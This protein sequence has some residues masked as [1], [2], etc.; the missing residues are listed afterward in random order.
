MVTFKERA[1]YDWSEDSV[2]IM[3]TPSSIARNTFF[4]VQEIGSFQTKP[5]YFTEREHLPSYLIVFTRGG[6]GYLTYDNKK[7]TLLPNQIFFIDCMNYHYYETDKKELWDIIWVHFNGPASQGHYHYFQRHE[8]P[9]VSVPENSHITQIMSNL[10][11]V[12]QTHDFHKEPI[13]SKLITDL[14][15]E[16]IFAAN[17]TIPSGALIPDSISSIMK[18]LEKRFN[19]RISLDQLASAHAIS[20]FHLVRE[21]KKYTGITPNEYLINCRISYAKKLLK[22]SD[23]SVSEIAYSVGIDN[24]SHFINLFKSREQITPLTYRKQWQKQN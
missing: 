3:A 8:S 15:T 18:E 1:S 4:Y 22:Y 2:R 10:L 14:L 17:T 11:D 20:K 16:L 23:L 21:F 9:V 13:S 7:Y 12:Q 6:K 24:V 5:N 19:A